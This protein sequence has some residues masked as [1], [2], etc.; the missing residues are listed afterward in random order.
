MTIHEDGAGS[1]H[2]NK[3]ELP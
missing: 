2:S 3:Q 1:G